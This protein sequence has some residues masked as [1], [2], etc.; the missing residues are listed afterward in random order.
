MDLFE[1]LQQRAMLGVVE[2][3]DDAWL[4]RVFRHYSRA[5]STPLHLVYELPLED[6]LLAFFEDIFENM[7]EEDREERIEWLLMSENERA[8]HKDG[9]KVLAD[10]DNAFLDSLNKS[11]A[12]G[13]MIQRPKEQKRELVVDESKS[14]PEG[15]SK[16]SK[17]IERTKKRA[18]KL[19]GADLPGPKPKPEPKEPPSLGDLPEI[20]MSFGKT[21]NLG[22]KDWSE[23]D[24]LAP[25]KKK[26]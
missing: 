23:L 9:E 14:P 26:R 4:R 20:S 17:L 6:V 16:L 22:G 15:M 3:D 11:V 12:S 1:A 10:R 5:F 2:P 13:E 25:P 8:E 7:D 18:A 21:S 24:P 19:A